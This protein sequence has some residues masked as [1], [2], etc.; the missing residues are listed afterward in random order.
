MHESPALY[1]ILNLAIYNLDIKSIINLNHLANKKTWSLFYT[2]KVYQKYIRLSLATQ[3]SIERLLKH[4]DEHTELAKTKPIYQVIYT[5][6]EESGYLKLLTIEDSQ[7]NK[8][9]LDFLNQFFKELKEWE[10]E[11]LNSESIHNFL[12]VRIRRI[13]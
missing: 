12:E 5:W 11:S 8:E 2:L 10:E 13:R 1:R 4:I 6:L 9:Q 7:K 3:R